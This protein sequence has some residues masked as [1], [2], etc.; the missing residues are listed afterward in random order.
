MPFCNMCEQEIAQEYF[1]DYRIVG[2]K[3][4]SPERYLLCE[5]CTDREK[6]KARI[7]NE[8]E[9]NSYDI[10]DEIELHNNDQIMDLNWTCRSCMICDNE[11]VRPKSRFYFFLRRFAEDAATRDLIWICRECNRNFKD[12][13]HFRLYWNNY[14]NS[15]YRKIKKRAQNL[16]KWCMK[17][18]EN[19]E[20]LS[21]VMLEHEVLALVESS[22]KNE[23]GLVKREFLQKL[24]NTI[25][26]LEQNQNNY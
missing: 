22:L 16:S 9:E 17:T 12:Y 11:N 7:F 19:G 8:A 5:T 2:N 18:T 15:Y 3:M 13:E 1:S 14:E 6:E 21:P 24:K 23:N 26:N 25:E 20:H 4:N 10:D